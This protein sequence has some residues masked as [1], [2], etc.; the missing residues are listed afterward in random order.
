MASKTK[1]ASPPTD[2]SALEIETPHSDALDVKT[3]ALSAA[4]RMFLQRMSRFLVNVQSAKY[5]H[6]AA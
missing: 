1:K 3:T 5:L 6:R 4:D 2:D